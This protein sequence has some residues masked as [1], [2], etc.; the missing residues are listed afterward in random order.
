M[1]TGPRGK[2]RK[3]KA[4][5]VNELEKAVND[6]LDKSI[7]AGLKRALEDSLKKGISREV[8]LDLV[9]GL[10]GFPREGPGKITFIQAHRFLFPEEREITYPKTGELNNV[11]LNPP[12]QTGAAQG[13]QGRGSP[14]AGSAG[15]NHGAA[16]GADNV[17]TDNRNL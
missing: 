12:P 4:V 10:T 8:L 9:G 2:S 16:G 15:G 5:E 14:A 7:P 3:G 6:F 13:S 17:P 1:I 11:Q